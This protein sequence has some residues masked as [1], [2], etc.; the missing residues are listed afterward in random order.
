MG[1]QAISLDGQ[2]AIVTGAGRGIGAATAIALARA[3][4]HVV[5]V[6]RTSDDLKRVSDETER[7]GRRAYM[8]PADL[9]DLEFV[10]GLPAQAVGEFGRLDIIVNNVGSATV[11]PYLDTEWSD[12]EHAMRANVAVAHTL[13][14]AAVPYL[15]DI[16]QPGAVVNVCSAVGRLGARGWLSY[17]MAKAA[18]A[19]YT[20][21]AARD[22][23]PGIRVNG[24]VPGAV[25]TDNLRFV[26]HDDVLRGRLEQ[27]TPMR[28]VGQPE[29]VADAIVYLA[30]SASSYVTGKLL[31]VDGGIDTPNI[32]LGFPDLGTVPA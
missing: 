16:S 27:A 10:A 17:G 1:Q 8:V 22:L 26:T 32:D 20:R 7:A 12:L 23:A 9:D 29:D 24:V 6:A 30:S 2:V 11:K 31:E 3:G 5:I 14:R 15:L 21:L 18:L 13:T 19:H 4:A 25:A 28:R